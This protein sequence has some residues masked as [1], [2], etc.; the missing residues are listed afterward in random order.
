MKKILIGVMIERNIASN[1]NISYGMKF[2]DVT[3][4]KIY[5]KVY[6]IS[7]ICL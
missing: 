5:Q 3:N 2:L 6:F 1:L 4:D 7:R